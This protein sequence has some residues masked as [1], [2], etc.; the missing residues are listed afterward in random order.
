MLIEKIYNHVQLKRINKSV[1]QYYLS[2][3]RFTANDIKDAD[4]LRDRL[5]AAKEIK[6]MIFSCYQDETKVFSKA[7]FAMVAGHIAIVD[8][9][10]SHLC[11][12]G[13]EK[14]GEA[15]IKELYN[16][17]FGREEG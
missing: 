11:E 9:A 8:C 13:K 12:L 15:F 16:E 2:A 7:P 14:Y 5:D 1:E 17:V 3:L 4:W 10:I 6:D